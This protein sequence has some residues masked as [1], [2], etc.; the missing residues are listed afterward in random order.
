MA[1]SRTMSSLASTA[2]SNK[3]RL[4]IRC[5]YSVIQYNSS[6]PHAIPSCKEA[7]KVKYGIGF[8]KQQITEAF[9]SFDVDNKGYITAADAKRILANFGFQDSEILSLVRAHDTNQDEKLQYDEFVRFW[10]VK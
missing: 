2:R 9:R 3:S 1:D 4:L 6:V 10:N 8:R 5:S 7:R